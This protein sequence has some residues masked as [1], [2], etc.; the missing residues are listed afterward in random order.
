M[1]IR[2][3]VPKSYI[4]CDS[5][6][7]LFLSINVDML[8]Y[9]LSNSLKFSLP[10]ISSSLLS[11]SNIQ[12][13][14]HICCNSSISLIFHYPSHPKLI[15]STLLVRLI[16]LFDTL[17]GVNLFLSVV[18]SAFFSSVFHIVRRLSQLQSCSSA[19]QTGSDDPTNELSRRERSHVVGWHNPWD[20]QSPAGRII[21]L[22]DGPTMRP[23]TACLVTV[24]TSPD[25][26]LCLPM[27]T[28]RSRSTWL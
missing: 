9:F 16:P 1:S 8:L 7:I 20:K 19:T 3:G 22:I 11:D 13:Y 24:Q 23:S 6:T 17:Y 10:H 15:S 26:T 21:G 4:C 14:K 2:A 28:V 25:G 5:L 18:L 27:D 12:N